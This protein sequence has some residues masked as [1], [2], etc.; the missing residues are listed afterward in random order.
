MRER[1][2]NLIKVKPSSFKIHFFTNEPLGLLE[3]AMPEVL[4]GV[5]GVG[6]T[7]PHIM[8]DWSTLFQL[9][10]NITPTPDF[11]TY[12]PPP[13]CLEVPPVMLIGA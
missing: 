2:K 9:G 4:E 6:V 1:K 10:E 13:Q 12:G 8:A 11:Q 7:A 5:G 3:L